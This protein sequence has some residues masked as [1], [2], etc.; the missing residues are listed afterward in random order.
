[1]TQA[2]QR[3]ARTPKLRDSV[4]QVWLAGLGALAVTEEEGSKVFQSLVK[5]GQGVERGTKARLRQAMTTARQETSSA[6]TRVESTVD[7]TLELVLH[8]LGVPTKQDIES[9]TRRIEGLAA[10][11]AER[12]PTRTRRAAATRTTTKRT[13]ATTRSRRKSARAT[14]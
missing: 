14:S 2:T 12:G 9:L 10:G 6:L 13:A 5:R 1:M 11:T 3:N 8:R 7:D 4:A